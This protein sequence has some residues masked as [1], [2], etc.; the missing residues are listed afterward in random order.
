MHQNTEKGTCKA[1]SASRTCFQN[2]FRSVSDPIPSFPDGAC[3]SVRNGSGRRHRRRPFRSGGTAVPA[4]VSGTTRAAAA[5]TYGPAR[6]PT[7]TTATKAE[8]SITGRRGSTIPPLRSA[9]PRRSSGSS[10][11]GP[12][13]P[14][15][16]GSLRTARGRGAERTADAP[17]ALPRL[18][19]PPVR[20]AVTCRGKRALRPPI[21]P[22]RQRGVAAAQ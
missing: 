21:G 3:S 10:P 14:R 7:S 1:K 15:Q 8:P 22:R 2:C 18:Q 17:R 16:G 9:A 5:A 4:A 6:V 11:R 19:G 12:A 13:A 20:R